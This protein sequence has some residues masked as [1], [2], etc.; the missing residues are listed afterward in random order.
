MDACAGWECD[1]EGVES[2]DDSR[3]MSIDSSPPE[4]DVEGRGADGEVETAVVAVERGFGEDEEDAGVRELEAGW[5]CAGSVGLRMR[6]RD[7]ICGLAV[8]SS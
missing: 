7:L 4:G 3:S 2:R 8:A 1:A 6:I 5:A